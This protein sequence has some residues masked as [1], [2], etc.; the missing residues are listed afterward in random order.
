MAYAHTSNGHHHH[1]NGSGGHINTIHHTVP[2]MQ[3]DPSILREL[4]PRDDVPL[5][6]RVWQV[7]HEYAI[8]P[9]MSNSEPQL[10]RD[11]QLLPAEG[12]VEM[13]FLYP[14]GIRTFSGDKVN[15]IYSL[16]YNLNGGRI[17]FHDIVPGIYEPETKEAARI[18]LSVKIIL[19]A[20]ED[21][22]E[23]IRTRTVIEEVVSR[24][25]RKIA[26]DPDGVTA[27]RR[28]GQTTVF[29]NNG[30]PHAGKRMQ[31][32]TLVTANNGNSASSSSSAAAASPRMQQ[33]GNAKRSR[34]MASFTDAPQQLGGGG[35]G[36]REFNIIPSITTGRH[37]VLQQQ[38][39]SDYDFTH[40]H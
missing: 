31:L 12:K 8:H 16:G 19:A 20:S 4:H 7:C 28:L 38:H 40:G 15:F 9:K 23:Y 27:R 26:T 14:P 10:E 5:V 33:S 35:G 29:D 1:G 18:E 2:A 36:G 21:R 39:H 30:S 11:I 37:D 6:Q 25:A 13:W 24:P 34:N 3:I 22:V 32:D 17:Q